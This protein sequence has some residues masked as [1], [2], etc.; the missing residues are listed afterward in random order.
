MKRKII[1]T[2]I[3]FLLLVNACNS[4]TESENEESLDATYQGVQRGVA[5]ASQICATDALMLTKDSLTMQQAADN[6]YEVENLYH[7][8]LK[9]T[10]VKALFD[11]PTT[12]GRGDSLIMEY[13]NGVKR[14][15]DLKM[16]LSGGVDI[17]KKTIAFFIKYLFDNKKESI[18]AAFGKYTSKDSVKEN[19]NRYMVVFGLP[20]IFDKEPWETKQ[21]EEVG[22][23]PFKPWA[24]ILTG[25]SCG[26]YDD[27]HDVWP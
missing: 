15:T 23:L 5:S 22:L 10:T 2:A 6:W 7:E 21:K 19:R 9:Q 12:V 20:K 24:K 26:F 14:S 16:K 1:P 8:Y 17:D 25:E 18:R 27:W 3:G 11:S 4:K 13:R